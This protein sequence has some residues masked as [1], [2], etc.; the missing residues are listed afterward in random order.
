MNRTERLNTILN[1]LAESGQIEVDEIVE[2]LAVST[3]WPP[4]GC[5]PAP[6]AER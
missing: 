6:A 1:L 2:K 5:C 4:R 3:A